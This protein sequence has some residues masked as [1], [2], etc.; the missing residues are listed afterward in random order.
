MLETNKIYLTDCVEGCKHLDDSCIDLVVTSPPYDNMRQYDCKQGDM[1][2][3]DTWKALISELYRVLKPGGVVVWIV[4]DATKDGTESG[5]SF[6]QA[7]YFI[8]CRFNLHDTMIWVKHGGGAIGSRYCYTQNFEYMFVFSKGSPKAVHL[9]EDTPTGTAEDKLITH[10]VNS[11][12]VNKVPNGL[13][14]HRT[15][16][17][18]SYVKRN[19]WWYLVAQPSAGSTFHPAVFPPELARDHIISW[20][21]KGDVVLD[22]FMGSGTTAVEAVKLGRKFIGFD[23]SQN[24]IDGAN[25]R[26][27]KLT[28]PFKLYGNIGC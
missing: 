18:K 5:T 10:N 20:S 2:H 3:E 26:L 8:E 14:I 19:N 24:Y 21:D 12:G 6:R 13:K 4:N 22:P 1:W 28:G 23:I 11:R 25:E 7:L 17:S 15:Y 9:I 27:K 16:T